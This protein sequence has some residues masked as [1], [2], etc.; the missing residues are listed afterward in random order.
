[1]LLVTYYAQNY[2]SIICQGLHCHTAAIDFCAVDPNHKHKQEA[3]DS[4]AKL[5]VILGDIMYSE[6]FAR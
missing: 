1:M 3:K 5:N 4:N 2:A 6:R